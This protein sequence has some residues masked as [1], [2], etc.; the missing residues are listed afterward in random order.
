MQQPDAVKIAEGAPRW[1][2]VLARSFRSHP[3][4]VLRAQRPAPREGSPRALVPE[5]PVYCSTR[6]AAGSPRG[7]SS[8]VGFGTARLLFCARIGRLP[9][10]GVI[11]RH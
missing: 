10:R 9:A 6:A 8:R 2:E 7:E 5:P 11:A 4:T 3:S 1:L